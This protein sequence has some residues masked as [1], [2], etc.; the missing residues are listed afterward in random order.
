M[1]VV[2]PRLR[3]GPVIRIDGREIV[4]ARFETSWTVLAVRFLPR[5]VPACLGGPCLRGA[6]TEGR[7][8][9]SSIRAD[10]LARG[11]VRLERVAVE[12]LAWLASATA[13]AVSMSATPGPNNAM[14]TASGATW[15]FRR[16]VPHMLGIAVGFPAMLVAVA[17]GAGD[18]LRER[19]WL[20]EALRWAGVAYLVWL[21]WKIGA[22]EPEP[23]GE[24]GAIRDQDSRSRPLSFVQA[25]LFQWVNPKA[26]VIALGAVA[27]YTTAAGS[28][29]VAQAAVLAL[30]LPARHAAHGG[31]LDPGGGRGGAG[32]EDAPRPAGLQSRHGGAAPAVARAHGARQVVRPTPSSNSRHQSRAHRRLRSCRCGGRGL[33]AAARREGRGP[34]LRSRGRRRQRRHVR[35][36]TRALRPVF[37]LTTDAPAAY[38]AGGPRDGEAAVT[39]R[40]AHEDPSGGPMHRR[41]SS[42][43]G[44]VGASALARTPS[45]RAQR[46]GRRGPHRHALDVVRPARGRIRAFK[47]RLK[48]LGYSEGENLVIEMRDGEGRNDRVSAFAADLVE[49][50]VD[51]IVPLGPYAIGAAKAATA[52]IPI[53]FTGIGTNFPLARSEGN[54]TGVAEE[55]IE[56]PAG[57]L[58]KEAVPSLARVGVIGNPGNYGTPAYLEKCRAW[59][60]AAGAAP[61]LRSA[62]SERHRADLREDGR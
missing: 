36:R 49:R 2:G 18:L 33:R 60:Q 62:R 54:T 6:S 34:R 42:K 53:V 44:L 41:A 55:L 5:F 26:W 57:R 59:A 61:S 15:G 9:S 19:P 11:A 35:E 50:R 7:L 46:P 25:A 17:L 3:S 8:A 4:A 45:A 43:S 37:A 29:L 48:A 22:A 30:D 13:F 40:P 14:V 27:A 47:A 12:G 21:A 24:P 20:H 16:T 38:G 51:L 58:L 1:R 56:S 28:G 10:F 52:T 32:A 23:P 31:A 39:S